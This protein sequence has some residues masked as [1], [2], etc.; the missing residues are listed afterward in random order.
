MAKINAFDSYEQPSKLF[1]PAADLTAPSAIRSETVKNVPNQPE[2][3]LDDCRLAV[4]HH[5]DELRHP[6]PPLRRR[7]RAHVLQHRDDLPDR[8]LV[9]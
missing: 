9:V 3:F 2:V 5:P 1:F 8:R 6:R 7:L 4:P